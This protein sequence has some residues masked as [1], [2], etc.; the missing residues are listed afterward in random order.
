MSKIKSLSISGF[1]SLQQ[2]N[3]LELRDLNVL[4]GANGAGKSNFISYFV[5]LQ[6]LIDGHLGAWTRLQGGADRILSFGV[7]ATSEL[8]SHLFFWPEWLSVLFTADCRLKLHFSARKYF[9]RRRPNKR[10]ER[11]SSRTV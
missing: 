4:I 7:K 6:R 11:G 8:K 5:M 2:V 1:K 3:D 10:S 9:L